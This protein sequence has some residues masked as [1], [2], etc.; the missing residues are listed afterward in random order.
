MRD[1]RERDLLSLASFPYFCEQLFGGLQLF[2]GTR[3]DCM[4]YGFERTEHRGTARDGSC[5]RPSS[6]FPS[7]HMTAGSSFEI[8]GFVQRTHNSTDVL[9]VHRRLLCACRPHLRCR[10]SLQPLSH[11]NLIL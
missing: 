4:L 1:G 2:T 9:C 7:S 8:D 6:R 11:L 3:H 10:I 5:S